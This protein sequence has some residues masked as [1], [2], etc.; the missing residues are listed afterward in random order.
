MSA[1]PLPF[2]RVTHKEIVTLLERPVILTV[3]GNRF[4][5]TPAKPFIYLAGGLIIFT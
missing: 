3:T 5:S 2:L 4:K 1:S